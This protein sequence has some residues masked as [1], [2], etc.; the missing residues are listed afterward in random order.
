MTRKGKT[1]IRNNNGN[2]NIVEH[3]KKKNEKK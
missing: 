1:M 2:E 3:T